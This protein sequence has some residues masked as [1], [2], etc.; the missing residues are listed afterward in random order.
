M[1]TEYGG[2]GDITRSME[3]LWGT[4]ERPTRGPKPSLT[5]DRIVRAAIELA[6]AEGITALSMRRV[7]AKL[8]VGTMS[9]YRYVPSKA[10]LLDLM[11][12]HIYGDDLQPPDDG[13]GW[14]KGLEQVATS[15]WELC[16][17]HAWLQHV[18][19]ARALLGPN[20][21]RSFEYS[22]AVLAGTGLTDG[23]R[24]STIVAVNNYVTG[25]ARAAAEAAE[26]PKRTGVT[27]EQFWSAQEPFLA[28]AMQSGQFPQ[29]AALDPNVF[30]E[31]YA[32]F[33][34]GLQRLLDGI[35]AYIEAKR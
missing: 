15:T 30:S 1:T 19:G 3:L 24:V 10:E 29:M 5:L 4:Q 17:R 14:R 7:A 16:H 13:R 35:E 11:L 8:E 18:S 34:F 28:K 27:D 6:D 21:T 25:Y 20:A 31:V 12:D 32:S 9:L 22:L 2:T 26:A 23:E 33:E